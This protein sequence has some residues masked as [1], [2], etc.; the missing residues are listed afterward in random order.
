M[1]EKAK[2]FINLIS[3]TLCYGV[4]VLH[5]AVVAAG[6]V[7]RDLRKTIRLQGSTFRSHQPKYM[8]AR[9]QHKEVPSVPGIR[10]NRKPGL[11]SIK[12]EQ[13]QGVESFMRR[14]RSDNIRLIRHLEILESGKQMSTLD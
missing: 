5:S 6:K 10:G 2:S 14:M 11:A 13:G 3:D 12:H 7:E 8:T 4:R 9:L 1:A